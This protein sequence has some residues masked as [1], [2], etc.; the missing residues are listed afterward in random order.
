MFFT[1]IASIQVGGFNEDT[2]LLIKAGETPGVKI[3]K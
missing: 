2:I 3:A 1:S